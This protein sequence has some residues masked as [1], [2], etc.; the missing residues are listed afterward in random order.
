[1]SGLERA[2][3]CLLVAVVDI[4]HRKST[5]FGDFYSGNSGSSSPVN[6]GFI[7]KRSMIHVVAR[8]GETPEAFPPLI[9][10]RFRPLC[11]TKRNPS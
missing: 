3:V 8:V 1:M 9:S 10:Q 5:H 11:F 2:T 7:N 6:I 4:L